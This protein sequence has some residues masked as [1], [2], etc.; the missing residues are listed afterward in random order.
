MY[1]T[2]W[3]LD[4]G[5]VLQFQ[6]YFEDVE[7]HQG[8]SAHSDHYCKRRGFDNGIGYGW[9]GLLMGKKGPKLRSVG[10][11]LLQKSARRESDEVAEIEIHA[12]IIRQV[13]GYS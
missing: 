11:S 1:A 2:V 5:V 10:A 7:N 4:I 13:N 8:S 6:E 9:V 3:N 12:R